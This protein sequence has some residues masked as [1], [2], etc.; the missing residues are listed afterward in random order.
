MSE[1]SSSMPA[2]DDMS[3]V[4]ACRIGRLV[5]ERAAGVFRFLAKLGTTARCCVCRSAS[6]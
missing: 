5:F 4:S 6:T 3:G 1:A 2:I